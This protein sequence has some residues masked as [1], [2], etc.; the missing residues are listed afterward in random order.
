MPISFSSIVSTSL[1]SAVYGVGIDAAAQKL[2]LY[3][4]RKKI[5]N[6]Q[7][8]NQAHS[9][10]T[11]K[12]KEDDVDNHVYKKYDMQRSLRYGTVA[13]LWVG[14]WMNIRFCLIDWLIQMN[15][16]QAA[17]FKMILNL[18]ILGPVTTTVGCGLN[19][20]LKPGATLPLVVQRLR[21]EF[22]RIQC[23]KWM[24]RPFEQYIIF[25]C[26]SVWQKQIAAWVLGAFMSMYVS[27]RLNVGIDDEEGEGQAPEEGEPQQKTARMSGEDFKKLSGMSP[28]S[29]SEG[30]EEDKDEDQDQDQDQDQE[31]DEDAIAPPKNGEEASA[32]RDED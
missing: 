21:Q 23:T 2:E 18:Y 5:K 8:Y 25:L 20:W 15:G 1:I 28:A 6:K 17:L 30:E 29:A 12:L 22:W 16:A 26:P 11:D 31:E 19:E 32:V 7:K 14:P 10:V 24:F 3:Y 9:T 13:L 4:E 27:F